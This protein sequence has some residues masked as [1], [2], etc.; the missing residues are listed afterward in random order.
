MT[1]FK[2]TA[3]TVALGIAMGTG[4]AFSKAH[5]QGVADG[6]FPESTSA[7]VSS[8]D[9][10]GISA[11]VGDGQR[12]DAASAN[13]DGNRVVPVDQPGQATQLPD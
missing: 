4:A 11:V 12:G 10:P 8:I 5:D 2:L 13:Q 6:E 3:A 1:S 9:G 7:V